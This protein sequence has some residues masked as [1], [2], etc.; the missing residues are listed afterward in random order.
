MER[1]QQLGRA[2]DRRLQYVISILSILLGAGVTRVGRAMVREFR[3]KGAVAVN[4]ETQ[5]HLDVTG[6]TESSTQT[7]EEGKEGCQVHNAIRCNID[8][9]DEHDN[10]IAPEDVAFFSNLKN[11][12]DLNSTFGLVRVDV[13]G[14]QRWGVR[15]AGQVLDVAIAAKNMVRV[16]AK[17]LG[18]GISWEE[19][20]MKTSARAAH[21]EA[22]RGSDLAVTCSL[23][24]H[25][26][27]RSFLPCVRHR[28]FTPR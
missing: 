5:C 28:S 13:P 15:C 16:T 20:K 22:A 21:R 7:E 14:K 18:G 11:R 6:H 10:E 8:F 4:A 9:D 19:Q 27:W 17:E 26:C 2:E 23:S 1:R 24:L 3:M 12:V 25:C